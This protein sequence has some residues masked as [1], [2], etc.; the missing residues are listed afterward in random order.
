MSKQ[1]HK[2]ISER[3]ERCEGAEQVCAWSAGA[4]GHG[5]VELG[6]QGQCPEPSPPSTASHTGPS[7]RDAPCPLGASPWVSVDTGKSAN[8]N[9]EASCPG[10]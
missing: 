2:V 5:G 8:G 9:Q 1:T 4:G 3:G 7:A 10:Q 6:C